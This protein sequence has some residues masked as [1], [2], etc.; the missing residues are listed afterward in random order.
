[1]TTRTRFVEQDKHAAVQEASRVVNET[2]PQL[3][4]RWSWACEVCGMAFPATKPDACDCCGTTGFTQV[5][6]QHR[7]ISTRW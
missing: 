4:I 5:T 3:A 6:D 7:E 2:S 1:M